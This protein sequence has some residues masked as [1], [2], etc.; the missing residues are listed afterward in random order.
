MTPGIEARATPGATTEPSSTPNAQ[1]THAAT[2]RPSAKPAPTA[3]LRPASSADLFGL[4]NATLDLPVRPAGMEGCAQGP[5]TKFGKG[6]SGE[7]TQIETAIE[8]DVD[9]DGAPEVVALV[10]CVPPG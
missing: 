10:D 3:S 5:G 9:H 2:P 6:R 1:P 8:A 4:A 7:T